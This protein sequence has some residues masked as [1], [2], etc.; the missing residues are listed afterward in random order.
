[1]QP[2]EAEFSSYVDSGDVICY[3]VH[4]TRPTPLP[5]LKFRWNRDRGYESFEWD[6][7]WEVVTKRWIGFAMCDD[8]SYQRAKLEYLEGKWYVVVCIAVII[9]TF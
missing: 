3:L 6:E 1:M 9:T 8:R 4:G 5:F 7:I 2:L